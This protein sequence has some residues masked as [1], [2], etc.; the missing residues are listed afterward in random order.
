MKAGELK[1]RMIITAPIDRVTMGEKTYINFATVWGS[2]KPIRG[3]ERLDQ[4]TTNADVTHEIRIRYKKGVKPDMR[5][6]Y[7]GRT[8]RISYVY[9]LFEIERELLLECEELVGEL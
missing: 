6:E 3:R 1:H 7:S 4:G 5:I 8:F 9:M 2:I